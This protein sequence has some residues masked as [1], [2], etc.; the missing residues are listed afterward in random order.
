MRRTVLA[1]VLLV[2]TVP[3]SA[4]VIRADYQHTQ[5]KFGGEPIFV[6]A[7]SH[8]VADD[9]RYRH[10]RLEVA[11]GELV[12]E[13]R[14]PRTRE[15]I[16]MRRQA[17]AP[18][19]WPTRA[20]HFVNAL[21]NALRYGLPSYDIVVER[22]ENLGERLIGELAV[23]GH[24]AVVDYETGWRSTREIWL[25]SHD[26]LWPFALESSFVT[27]DEDGRPVGVQELWVTST[28]R[29]PLDEA[30]FKASGDREVFGFVPPGSLL[31]SAGR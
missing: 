19:G 25:A 8:F 27:T 6:E 18:V 3:A 10:D 28:E 31:A 11:S 17:Q 9:G 7:G 21:A 1:A 24:R 26:A 5:S 30:L 20:W 4:Q 29:I 14:L 16:V 13:I 15:R 2:L 22:R 23:R 12:S